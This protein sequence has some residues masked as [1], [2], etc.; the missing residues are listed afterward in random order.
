MGMMLV[1][2][3]LL[4]QRAHPQSDRRRDL[5]VRG[6]VLDGRGRAALLHF[7]WRG[8]T[9]PGPTASGSSPCFTRFEASALGQFDLRYLAFHLSVCVFVLYLTV[10]VL[11]MRANR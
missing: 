9:P 1:A 8:S 2:I 3:G 11:E 7:A 10:K 4:L 6:L 5:D